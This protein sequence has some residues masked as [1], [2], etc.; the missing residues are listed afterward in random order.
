MSSHE[1]LSNFSDEDILLFHPPESQETSPS[2][3]MQLDRL[4]EIRREAF[5]Y[6]D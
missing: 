5:H 4:D 1:F 3:M 2:S 6:Q